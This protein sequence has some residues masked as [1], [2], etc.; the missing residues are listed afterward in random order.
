MAVYDAWR[1]RWP[2][3]AGRPRPPGPGSRGHGG[4]RV[5]T[6]QA[7]LTV[8]DGRRTYVYA[9]PL[10]H[11]ERP[12][13]ALAV[14]L[15]ASSLDAAEWELWRVNAVRFPV[16]A[17]VLSLIAF[18]VVRMSIT[19]PMKRMAGWTRALRTGH[20][21]RRRAARLVALRLARA[22]VSGIAKSLSRARLAAE[23]E[24]ALRVTGDAVWTEE[25]LKQ[26]VKLRLGGPLVVVSNR[27]PVSHVRSAADRG[28]DAGERPGHRDGP[29]ACGRAAGVWVAHG[30]GE[31]DREMVDADER[32]ARA[33]PTTRY[34]L[35]RVWLTA[36]EEDG[37]YYGFSNE[38]LWPLCHIVH[39]RPLFRPTDWAQYRR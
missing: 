25:R 22:E 18:L 2:G 31:A 20:R 3:A 26:F 1:A 11:E 13:G 19:D 14:F 9:T 29:R 10:S 16:L 17:I 15:D 35:R 37:Y 7:R 36:E 21:R 34:T 32:V 4:H 23:E 38:G 5:G 24:A 33:R 8:I 28:G 30:S 27:E 39:T 12:A 6:A